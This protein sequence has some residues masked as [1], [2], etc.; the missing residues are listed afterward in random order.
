MVMDKSASLGGLMKGPMAPFGLMNQV[1]GMMGMWG[2]Q[3]GMSGAT[4]GINSLNKFLDGFGSM[5]ISSG[6]MLG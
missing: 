2:A 6:D 5:P 1:S 4:N 3:A